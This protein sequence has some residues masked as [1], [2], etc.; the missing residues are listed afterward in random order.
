ML[1]WAN[2]YVAQTVGLTH[3]GERPLGAESLYFHIHGA[4]SGVQP[5]PGQRAMCPRHAQFSTIFGA[6]K[7]RCYRTVAP[8]VATAPSAGEAVTEDAHDPAVA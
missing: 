8:E 2:E 1:G 5:Q 7:N 3:T 6:T 4:S